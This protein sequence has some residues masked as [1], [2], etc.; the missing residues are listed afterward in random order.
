MMEKLTFIEKNDAIVRLKN[1]EHFDKDCE[2]LRKLNPGSKL[3]NEIAKVN[4]FS[5]HSV[6]GRVL[7]ELLDFA[8]IKDIESNRNAIKKQKGSKDNPPKQAPKKADAA[9]QIDPAPVEDPAA[10]APID[11]APVED[12]A[13]A[14]PIDPAP[15]EEPAA[16]KEEKKKAN[17]SKK[18]IQE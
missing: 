15:D 17:K 8:P 14:A 1:P 12:P 13:A 16:I 18:S 11:P 9:A 7:L 3:H 6:C 2:L 5:I 10:A 4:E